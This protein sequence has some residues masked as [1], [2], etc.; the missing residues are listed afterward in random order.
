MIYPLIKSLADQ[1]GQAEAGAS[2]ASAI[3]NGVFPSGASQT[4]NSSSDVSPKAEN[5]LAKVRSIRKLDPDV[6]VE[7]CIVTFLVYSNVIDR[8]L[9][10][11]IRFQGV[12]V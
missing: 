9:I 4:T 3:S 10:I 12:Y 5:L 6:D 11:L 8:C 1:T 2:D 7:E